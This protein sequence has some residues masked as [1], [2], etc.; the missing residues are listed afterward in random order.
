MAAEKGGSVQ[1][2]LHHWKEERL[3]R[4]EALETAQAEVLRRAQAGEARYA[5]SLGWLHVGEWAGKERVEA[6]QRLAAEIRAKTDTF[7]LIG[8]GGSNN[9]ARSAISALAGEDAVKIVYAGNT[10][11]PAALRQAMQNAAGRLYVDCIAKNFE[12]LEP[13]ASFRLFRGL[14]RERC[15][16]EASSRIAATGS[17]GSLLERLCAEQGYTFLEFPAN[18][19]G[20]YTALTSVGLLPMAAAGLDIAAMAEGAADMER[21]LRSQG[22]GENAAYRYA[23][24]RRLCWEEGYRIELLSSFDPR[25]HWFYKWWI[26]LFAESEGKEGKGLFPVSGEFSEELHAVGQFVQEGTPLLFETFLDVEDDGDTLA[27]APDGIEDDFGYLDGRTFG[28]MNSAAYEATAEAHSRRLPCATLSLGRLDEYHFG[29]LFY[30]FE[31]AC[32]LSGS[33]LGVNPFDQPGVEDYKKR[34]FAALGKTL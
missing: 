19:G 8:V 7:V 27:P 14:L 26:Q 9:A 33:L 13:G 5:N 30:F 22:P 15:G 18:V 34:M 24:L 21:V 10:L 4:L 20:R 3:R 12:T 31:F 6:L 32:Y 2:K 17:R 11:S 16:G 23:C 25:L 1:I 28:A 29:A